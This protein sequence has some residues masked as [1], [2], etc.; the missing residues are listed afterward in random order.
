MFDRLA[1]VLRKN[2][3]AR[4]LYGLYLRTR[5]DRLFAIPQIRPVDVQRSRWEGDRLNLL[6]PSVNRED[7]Y[8]GA[9]TALGLFEELAT[10]AGGGRCRLRLLLTD[11]RPDSE[12]LETFRAYRF[13]PGLEDGDAARQIVFLSPRGKTGL[14]VGPGDRFV[15]TAWWTA[16]R[17]QRMIED[18]Q[19]LFALP[20]LPHLAYVIQDYEPGFYNW[21]SNFVL[22][23]ATYRSAIPTL[24]VFNTSLLRD[25]FRGLGYRF[26]AEYSFEPRLNEGLRE[27]ILRTRGP[28]RKQILVYGRPSVD[29]NCFP[30]V[31]EALREWTR[32]QPS[33]AEWRVLSAGEKHPPVDLGGGMTLASL[34]KLPLGDYARLLTESAVGLSL[35]VSPHPSYPPLEMAHAGLLTLTNDYANKSLSGAHDN[36]HC[37]PVLTPG[38]VAGALARLT[39]AFCADPGVGTAGKSRMPGYT[40]TSPQFPF[41]G[42]LA[43]RLTE[44]CRP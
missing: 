26:A 36:L 17:A 9:H 23:D 18:Q 39:A 16:Y 24:A 14:R 10:R 32:L 38:T 27:G 44:P 22:A 11:A 30:L 3:T 42:D 5:R 28:R 25:F 31:V 15:A 4:K 37:L 34:G 41:L 2:A 19:R 8:G 43:A 33:A 6:L 21:S 40:G 7:F 12:A 29:R 1:S 35:M 13:A 20:R